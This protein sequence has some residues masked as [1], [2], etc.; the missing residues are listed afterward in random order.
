VLWSNSG[1]VKNNQHYDYSA[2]ILKPKNGQR[3]QNAVGESLP[4]DVNPTY[5]QTWEAVGYPE[6]NIWGQN[7]WHCESGFFRKDTFKGSGPDPVG[8]G[9]N[10]TGGSSGGPWLTEDGS[11]GA[12]T[13]YGY[14]NQ[15]DVLYGTYLGTD[16]G[17]LYK[18]IRSKH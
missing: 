10:M 18:K 4:L 8:I 9:C 1:W 6:A 15:P 14:N 16:A 3:V 7:L 12:V 2:A 17:K 5:S 11:L 13:S